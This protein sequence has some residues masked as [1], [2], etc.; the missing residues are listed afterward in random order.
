MPPASTIMM[1]M[2][3]SSVSV[4]ARPATTSSKVEASP[5]SKVGWGIQV[6]SVE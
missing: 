4:R 6:P 2:S 3:V 1:A 5:S